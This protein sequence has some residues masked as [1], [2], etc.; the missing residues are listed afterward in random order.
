MKCIALCLFVTLFSFGA[1]AQEDEERDYRREFTWGLNK[2][3]YSGLIGGVVFKLAF[4]VDDE[5]SNTFGLEFY[6]VSH[7][8]EFKYQNQRKFVWGK[9]NNLYSIRFMYGREKLLYRKA[10]QQG[11]QIS[12]I[13]AGGPTWG[14]VAPYYVFI[15]EQYQ[16]FGDG[17]DVQ[18]GS[19]LGSGKKIPALGEAKSE[20]GFNAK[21]GLSFEFGSFKNTVAGVEAGVALEAFPKKI[22]IMAPSN[23]VQ[24]KAVFTSIYFSLYWGSRR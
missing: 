19:V 1:F 8:K 2:N 20:I 5:I 18:I 14:L 12:S 7:P 10:P 17:S 23:T 6:N 22:P 11:V 15:G 3:T 9:Q 21:T 13:F 16:K 24:N 4:P